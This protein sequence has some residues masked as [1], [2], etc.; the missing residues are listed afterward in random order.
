MIMGNMVN[1]R[2]RKF[3]DSGQVQSGLSLKSNG[4]KHGQ[5]ILKSRDLEGMQDCI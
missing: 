4:D 2:R 3:S 5:G 1:T